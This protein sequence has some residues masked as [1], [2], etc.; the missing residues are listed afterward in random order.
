MNDLDNRIS[1]ED[2][3]SEQEMTGEEL[4][5]YLKFIEYAYPTPK[6]DL[7]QAVSARIREEQYQSSRIKKKSLI[8]KNRI[9]SKIVKWSSLAACIAIICLAGIKVIPSLNA[10][11]EKL[12]VSYDAAEAAIEEDSENYET[13]GN[14]NPS[15][16]E[17]GTVAAATGTSVETEVQIEAD[18]PQ[19]N[20]ESYNSL[21]IGDNES[22]IGDNESVIGDNESVIGNDGNS[23][24][25]EAPTEEAADTDTEANDSLFGI[26]LYSS[27]KVDASAYDLY[28]ENANGELTEEEAVEETIADQ[29]EADL[30]QNLIDEVRSAVS[31]EIIPASDASV[32][33]IITTLGISSELFNEILSDLTDE[34][35]SLYPD[36]D[37]PSYNYEKITKDTVK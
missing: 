12:A 17:N 30:K 29:F 32:E 28:A 13:N 26:G 35:N 14:N 31:E 19:Y 20:V 16:S 2:E 37:I 9:T 34:Y 23:L 22:V 5:L 11:S 10:K 1:R 24:T 8:N 4:T 27:M 36:A 18:I 6:T 25:Y 7:R 21:F 15:A 33:E 3:D